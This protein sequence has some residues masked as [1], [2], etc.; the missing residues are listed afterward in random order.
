MKGD[1][2]WCRL[3]GHTDSEGRGGCLRRTH[4]LQ[5]ML[6]DQV[7]WVALAVECRLPASFAT[8]AKPGNSG[9][10][11]SQI[12]MDIT[13]AHRLVVLGLLQVG[14]VRNCNNPPSHSAVPLLLGY[15]LMYWAV[16]RTSQFG[17][18]THCGTAIRTQSCT[19]L[20]CLLLHADCERDSSLQQYC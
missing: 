7:G 18:V 15:I 17:L 12:L 5:M 9:P 20:A 16:P 4:H 6:P 1:G 3:H 10:Q 11:G 13:S 14:F 19:Y 8:V 2:I